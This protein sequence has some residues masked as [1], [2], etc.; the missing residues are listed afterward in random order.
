M[1][2]K[3]GIGIFVLIV[4]LL[5]LANTFYGIHPV[6]LIISLLGLI[7][8]LSYFMKKK[9]A[10]NLIMVWAY[11]Q[12]IIIEPIWDASQIFRI[13]FGFEFNKGTSS[14]FSIMFNFISLLYLSIIR[15][16]FLNTH[17]DKVVRLKPYNSNSILNNYLPNSFVIISRVQLDKENNW[18]LIK[19]IHSEEPTFALI[20]PKEKFASFKPEKK[21]TLLQYRVVK[22]LDLVKKINSSEDFKTGDFVILF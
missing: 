6:S 22:D 13:Q 10:L 2:N 3:N 21:G 5:N 1:K 11:S 4:S 15:L 14:H 18:Y 12:I 20:R 8:S 19:Q 7:A 9:W 17:I 16:V